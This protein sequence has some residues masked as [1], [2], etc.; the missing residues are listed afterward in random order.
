M[1]KKLLIGAGVV[2]VAGASFYGY[3]TIT[4][5]KNRQKAVDNFVSDLKKQNFDEYS[6]LFSKKSLE[7]YTLTNKKV[8]ERYETIFDSI[9]V[10]KVKVT[11]LKDEKYGKKNYRL[12]Y[13]LELTTP[14]GVIKPEKYKAIYSKSSNGKY[15]FKWSSYLIFPGMEATDKVLLQNDVVERG[16][17]LD[18]NGKSLAENKEFKQIGMNPTQLGDDKQAALKEIGEAIDMPVEKLEAL[19]EPEWTKGDVFVPIKVLN[20]KEE[21]A[22]KDKLPTGTSLITKKQRYYPLEQSAAHLIGYVGQPTAEDLD[23]NPDLDETTPVGRMGLEQTLDNELRGKNGLS[24]VITTAKGDVKKT[25]FKRKAVEGKTIK[26]TLDSDAQQKAFA[27]LKNKPGAMVASE[28]KTGDL[29]VSTSSPSFDPNQFVSGIGDKAYKELSEDKNLPFLARY[30]NRYAPGSTFKTITAAIGL[31]AGVI[32]PEEALPIDGLKWQ[33]DNS[34]GGFWTTRVKEQPTVNLEQALVYSDNIYFAQQ[35]LKMGEKTL[36]DG[37]AKFPFGKEMS[38]PIA[39]EPASIANEK[40]L[41]NDILLADTAYGQGQLMMTPLQ[42]LEM[43]SVFMTD[44]NLISPKLVADAK[45]EKTDGVI[46]AKSAHLVLNDLVGTVANEDGYAHN[47]YHDNF[48]LAAKTGTAE[49]KEKQ[50]TVGT[51]NSF[52]LFLDQEK[53]RFMGLVFSEDSR[54]NGAANEKAEELVNY[55]EQNYN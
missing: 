19:L 40:K 51:E 21:E 20:D 27:S 11:N 5:N 10:T 30:A 53:S 4:D 16:A 24:L 31:D 43:Y 44:G 38:L 42:Q 32:K 45:N 48:K 46:S 35:A 39:M 15:E 13:N 2:L 37:L 52:L 7:D 47:L 54:K 1:K 55:L 49:I 34:W 50:D 17:I 25:V 41:K 28:P 18:R 22:L 26:L 9:G 29:L 3:R 8:K 6:Q 14:E 36:M 12:T 23:K 33:K